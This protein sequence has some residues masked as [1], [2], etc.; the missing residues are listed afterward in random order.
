MFVATSKPAVFARKI[1]QH[2]ELLE[3]FTG[4]YGAELSGQHSDKGDLVAHL[5]RSEALAPGCVTMIGD[6]AHDMI[7]AQQ[8]GVRAVGVLWGYG[9]FAELRDAGAHRV[10]AEVPELMTV[11]ASA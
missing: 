5:L 7:G 6:R 10:I 1:L 11:V 3:Y 9:S 8:N 4:V 2:F